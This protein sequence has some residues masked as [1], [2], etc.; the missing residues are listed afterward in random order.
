MGAIGG[1]VGLYGAIWGYMKTYRDYIGLYELYGVI[2]WGYR[3]VIRDH[4][5]VIWGALWGH[6]EG[7]KEGYVGVMG[8]NAT[9]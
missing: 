8:C 6:R 4:M 9:V 5:G 7:Y 3:G 1:Y 2:I